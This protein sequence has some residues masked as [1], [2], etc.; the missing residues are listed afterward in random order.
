MEFLLAQDEVIPDRCAVLSSSKGSD[1]ALAMGIHLDKV[2]AVITIGGLLIA[3]MT[4]LTYKG[5]Q[6]WKGVDTNNPDI[7]VGENIDQTRLKK[8]MQEIFRHDHP[9]IPQ[10][11]KASNDTF[12][13]LVA[14]DDDKL[15]TRYAAEAVAQRM[16]IH[17]REN[18]CRTIIYPK[19]GHI[20]EMPYN[21]HGP[22]SYIKVPISSKGTMELKDIVIKWGGDP[23][24]TCLAQEDFWCQ[25]R[26]FIDRH[27]RDLSHWYQNFL[28]QSQITNR[29]EL[30]KSH[31]Q[32]S[33]TM[34]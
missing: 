23:A 7:M 21:A 27:I 31:D 34:C 24:G 10:C 14:G 3:S 26:V 17:G 25:L 4:T 12:F 30:K 15:C 18:N 13:F 28:Q 22:Y 6:I 11:E 32:T 16:K 9:L 1:T 8:M 29:R 33:F 5:Q 19:V 20:L 2:K